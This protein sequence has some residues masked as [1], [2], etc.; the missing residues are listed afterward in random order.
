MNK[1]IRFVEINIAQTRAVYPEGRFIDNGLILFE[2]T[3]Q[4][5][6]PT[7]PSRVKSLFLALYT[8]GHAQYAVDTKM[9]KVGAGDAITISGRQVVADCMFSH[10]CRGVVPILSCDSFRNIVSGVHEL[11]ALFP[12]VHAHLIFRLN[13]NQAKVLEDDI[14]HIKEKVIDADHRFR[15]E[16]VMTTLKVL[17]IDVGGII[18][19]FQQVGE[20]EQTRAEAIFRDFIQTVERNY[21][22]ERRIGRYAQQLYITSKYLSETVRIA[23]RRTPGDWI[24]SYATRKLRVV[25]RNGTMSVKRI[26]DELNFVSQS[27]MGRYFKGHVGVSPSK[28]GKG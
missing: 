2:N 24:D 28:F 15:R 6:L 23:S 17:I 3:M 27:F 18:H 4:I 22:T 20:A 21:H 11:S 5:P 16:L 10:D 1:E 19:R 26:A 14:Q 7:S 13:S 9:H 8:S 25:L 12:S